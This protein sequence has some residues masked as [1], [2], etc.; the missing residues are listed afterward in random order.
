MKKIIPIFIF[1]IGIIFIA[2]A[3]KTYRYETIEGDPFGT[4]IYTLQNG[5]KVYMS[6]YKDA[7][8]DL[9]QNVQRRHTTH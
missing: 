2:P 1:L 5:L 4:K 7:V 6:V 9:P 3:Q 8:Y